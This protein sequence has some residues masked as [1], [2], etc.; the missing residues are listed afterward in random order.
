[1]VKP[2]RLILLAT[3][4][5]IVLGAI[6]TWGVGLAAAADNSG[7][8]SCHGDAASAPSQTIDGKTVS[9]YVDATAYAAS[10]HGE[11]AC[12]ACHGTFGE[13]HDPANRTYGS[14]AR[15]SA[16]ASTDTSAT[17]NFWKVS[18]DKCVACH[19]DPAYAKFFTSDHST[20]WNLMHNPDGS[21]RLE[22]D[23][24]GSDG[25]TYHANEDYTE[26]N[27][28]R[29]HMGKNCAACHWETPIIQNPKNPSVAGDLLDFWSDYSAEA[30]A[31][32]TG[33]AEYAIDWTQ[34]IATHDFR[35]S[36]ELESSNVVCAACHIGFP[37]KPD[38]S[39]P[40][41]GI[42]GIGMKRHG[43]TQELQRAGAR[44]V[45]ETLQQCT[46]CHRDV[47]DA[48][49]PESMLQWRQDHDVNCVDCHPDRT[50][51]GAGVPHQS[52][53]CTACHATQVDAIL[54]PDGGGP[55]VPLV[56]P[57]VI[58]HN[59]Q[60][61]WP[62]HDL[63]RDTDCQRCHVQGGNQT[64]APAWSAVMAMDP[65][66]DV[67]AP[68]TKALASVSVLR[69]RTATFKYRVEDVQSLLATV[70]IKIRNSHGSV[71]KTYSLGKRSVNKALAFKARIS[72]R[73]GTY[74]W[75]VYAKDAAGNAQASPAGKRTLKVR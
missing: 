62:T 73:K 37:E 41:I 45:H 18:G 64:G 23:V 9:L 72:L 10:Q 39:I 65:H 53:D 59:V 22:V 20:A 15:F 52:V 4:V 16:S 57:R 40:A 2:H 63:R 11:Q 71:V 14:W 31:L 48:T 7:C 27:C 6:A 44:G 17:W 5:L 32:K 47:H 58:K 43:Q 38:A 26:A 30:S 66:V 36:T 50:I 69:Y 25:L 29:C 54:D 55:G 24:V 67:T 33:L 19:T 74:T 70:T 35:S 21:P 12:T 34:N 3:I 8:L 56:I 28:G 42:Y 1:M 51:M 46:D 13:A 60:Q 75:T 49:A 68:I 61:G